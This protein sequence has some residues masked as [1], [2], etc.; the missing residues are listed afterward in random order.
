MIT[1]KTNKDLEIINFVYTFAN[2]KHPMQVSPEKYRFF[3]RSSLEKA[4]RE[5]RLTEFSS[6]E[7]NVSKI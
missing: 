1:K 7:M 5:V 2:E 3:G 6:D 4:R